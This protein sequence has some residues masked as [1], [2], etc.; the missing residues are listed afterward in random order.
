MKLFPFACPVNLQMEL[1]DEIW[2]FSVL[3]QV[4]DASRRDRLDT[5]TPMLGPMLTM[6]ERTTGLAELHLPGSPTGNFL[7]I[8]PLC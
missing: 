5:W 4:L 3:E 8:I 1:L 6:N 7:L 2:R